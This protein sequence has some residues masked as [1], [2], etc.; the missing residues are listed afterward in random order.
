VYHQ[1]AAVNRGVFP[2]NRGLIQ[3]ESELG[4]GSVFTV[5][6][7]LIVKEALAAV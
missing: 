2:K 4:K 5:T 1:A 3:V 7:P 6:L